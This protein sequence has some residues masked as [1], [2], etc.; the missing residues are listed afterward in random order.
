[1][2]KMLS[3]LLLWG[4]YLF[5]TAQY[6]P[7][8]RGEVVEHTYFS[9][10]YKES[11]EQAEW[12]YYQLTPAL[13]SGQQNRTDN[14]R[15]DSKVSTGSAS[16]A[17][18]KSSGYDRGHL[19]P[20]ADMKINNK[21]M[22]ETFLMSNMSPQDPSFNRGIWKKLEATVRSWALSQGPIH[23]A[24]AGILSANC[25]CIGPNQVAVPLYFYKVIYAPATQMMIA[26]ILPN[27]GSN[28]PL[29]SY[30]VSVDEVEQRTGL[31]FFPQLDDKL[32]NRLEAQSK[33]EQWSFEA[34]ASSP[35][36]TQSAATDT[37]CTAKTAKGTRCKRQAAAG[38][39]HCWQH[40]K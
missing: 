31:D 10:S 28:K 39:T 21:A 7:S 20:A 36:T 18:Y 12:V 16:L 5:A 33:P 14:F 23:I 40:K 37:Q 24:T 22:H 3:T 32:E 13:V 2:Y 8:A 19:C 11:H 4:I 35:S 34:P 15:P 27:E 29:Q 25:A 6:Q 30:V 1:M 26:F 17:D 9:L 38:T